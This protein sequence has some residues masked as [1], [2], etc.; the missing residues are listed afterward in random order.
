MKTRPSLRTWVRRRVALPDGCLWMG[1]CHAEGGRC[2]PLRAPVLRSEPV[3]ARDPHA[4]GD[5][6]ADPPPPVMM[7][8]LHDGGAMRAPCM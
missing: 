1:A 6:S 2:R 4:P 3:G 7:P 8:S 5:V